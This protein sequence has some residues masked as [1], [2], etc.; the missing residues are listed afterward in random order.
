[1]SSTEPS[2]LGAIWEA[3][4][5]QPF[6]PNVGKDAQF[7]VGF[8]LLATSL[9]LTALFGLSIFVLAHCDE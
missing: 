8:V 3:S 5:Q 7:L 9:I 2:S 4:A 6:F 1:M